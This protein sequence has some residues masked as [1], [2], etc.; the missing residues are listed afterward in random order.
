MGTYGVALLLIA[1]LT[2]FAAAATF[3]PS[4]DEG[5]VQ[6]GE[7]WAEKPFKA[8]PVVNCHMHLG[9]TEEDYDLTVKVMDA[10]GQAASVDLSGG[11][12]ERLVNKLKYAQ[13]YPGRFV[14][15]CNLGVTPE[16]MDQPGIGERIA[17][18]IEEA[19]KAGAKGVGEIGPGSHAWKAAW[20]DPRFDAVWKKAVEL[21]V[22]FNWHIAQPARY[23]RPE[24]AN[25]RIEGGGVY[26]K[27]DVKPQHA[28][29]LER[30][31]VLDRYPD[32]TVIACHSSYAAESAP[33]LNYLMETYPNL[34]ID[35]DASFEE[36]GKRPEEFYDFCVEYQ[37]RIL[38]GTDWGVSTRHMERSGAQGEEKFV[39]DWKAFMLAHYLFLGT[40][41]RMVPC[42]FN[43]NQ[44]RIL[45][46]RVNGFPRYAHDGVALPDEVLAKLYYKNAEKLFGL[47]VEGWQPP[48][49]IAWPGLE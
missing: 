20:D 13:K 17:A 38:F 28:Y 5:I 31:R 9:A 3:P 32:L 45:T 22:P 7:V 10:T 48:Q 43:G 26:G 49:T 37:D 34:Y 47:K 39:D 29:Q 25:N 46:H 19:V 15:F 6:S 18:N 1:F 36:W 42:P 27:P 35:M 33:Y 21:K 12:G 8:Y 11:N 16:E 41:Q 23:W 24:S 30:D 40:D 4:D 44:G 2:F 14:V